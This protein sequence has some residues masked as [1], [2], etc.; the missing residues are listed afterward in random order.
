MAR[1]VP[2]PLGDIMKPLD[3]IE[4]AIRDL[5]GELDDIHTLPAVDRQLTQLNLG[6]VAILEVLGEIRDGL[7][8]TAGE[9]R[10]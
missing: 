6:I 5:N 8:Q 9:P 7:N 2:N 3:R 4:T 1:L 10:S